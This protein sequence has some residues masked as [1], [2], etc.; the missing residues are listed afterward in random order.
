MKC[1]YTLFG[2]PV[3]K[4]LKK[5]R[6]MPALRWFWG[7]KPFAKMDAMKPFSTLGIGD[8][9]NGCTN[10]NVQIE[11]MRPNYVPIGN[12]RL[13]I[14]IGFKTS[15]GDC[16]L[17]YCGIELPI[18]FEEAQRRMKEML[19]TDKYAK[20]PEMVARYKTATLNPNG[21]LSYQ[22]TQAPVG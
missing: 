7:K 1:H 8:W 9:I 15:G 14:D 12:G 6:L 11:E 22:E 13:L 10:F 19:E 3:W 4:K 2:F 20:W 17:P 21:S 18:S 5:R 16:S